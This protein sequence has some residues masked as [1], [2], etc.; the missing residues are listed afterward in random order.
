[1]QNRRNP[2]VS[3]P[4]NLCCVFAS[5]MIVAFVA[6]AGADTGAPPASGA[7]S[8]STEPTV[9]VKL[10]APYDMS[11]WSVD[12]GGGTSSGGAF[13]VTGAIGQ[14][15]AG[16]AGGCAVVL[17]GGLW[18]GPIPCETPLFCDGFESGGSGAWSGVT[19]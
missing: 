6:T 13:A 7:P 18:S 5:A 16:A 1:M 19:P 2:G 4:F 3:F 17:D 8:S 10:L 11:W 15:D 14:P 9:E 12:G